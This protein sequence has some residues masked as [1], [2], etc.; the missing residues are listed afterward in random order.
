MDRKTAN[1]LYNVAKTLQEDGSPVGETELL[2]QRALETGDPDAYAMIRDMHN[3]KSGYDPALGVLNATDKVSQA[4]R[5]LSDH[6]KE[7]NALRNQLA[8]EHIARRIQGVADQFKAEQDAVNAH[9]A[10][11]STGASPDARMSPL[12]DPD[13][14][15]NMAVSRG[16]VNPDLQNDLR[17][18]QDYGGFI[19]RSANDAAEAFA[20]AAEEAKAAEAAKPWYQKGLDW[21]D[22]NR[23]ATAGILAGVPTAL[24]A[25]YIFNKRR[26]KK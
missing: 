12:A 8:S 13:Y 14:R 25:A 7:A 11:I 3:P 24:T 9:N 1:V 4:T 17:Y 15:H 19:S 23:L 6:F 21:A 2:A 16:T 20:D 22:K 26:K 10:A 18:N 5:D